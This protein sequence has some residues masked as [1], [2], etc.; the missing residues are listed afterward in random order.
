MSDF[1]S[2]GVETVPLTGTRI[3]KFRQQVSGIPVYGSLVSVELDDNNEVVSLNSN[4][5]TPDVPS[6]LAKVS[7]QDALKRVASEAGYGRELPEIT[8][9]L[10]FYLDDKG[11]WQLVYIAEN[12]RSRK[13]PRGRPAPTFMSPANGLRLRHRCAD[14]LAGR[15]VAAHAIDG[16]R[17]RQGLGRARRRPKPSASTPRGRSRSL[18]DARLNIETYDFKFRDPEAHGARVCPGSFYASSPF[19]PSAAMSA[20]ANASRRRLVLA[21]R[22][23]AQQHRQQGRALDLDRQLR[24]EALRDPAGS[25][26]W[27][28]AF[29]DPDASR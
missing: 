24:G 25:K 14:R 15:R 3:V 4:L 21:R 11:K 22:A 7:P 19:W 9:A 18:R 8:P 27:L 29:W 16:R 1:K 2:L 26:N 5:A 23:Q 20:H 17:H 6:Y 13:E 28:N 10:N 12:V